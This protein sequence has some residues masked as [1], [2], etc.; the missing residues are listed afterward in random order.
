MTDLIVEEVRQARAEIAAEFGYDIVKYHEWLQAQQT[1]LKQNRQTPS[2]KPHPDPSDH[3]RSAKV[4]RA[5]Q[6]PRAPHPCLSLNLR[7]LD[8]NPAP[9]FKPHSPTLLR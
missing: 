3:G 8:S 2:S 6:A 9:I 5:P 1:L 4:S 7:K